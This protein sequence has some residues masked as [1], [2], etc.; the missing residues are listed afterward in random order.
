MRLG[1]KA[2]V[3]DLAS[4]GE[5]R[6]VV[7]TGPA[8]EQKKVPYG[9]FLVDI[10]SPGSPKFLA[11]LKPVKEDGTRG[12]AEAIAILHSD[13]D[14]LRVV[15]MFDSLPSGGPREYRVPLR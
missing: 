15:V 9:L 12:K 2:G 11:T 6:F 14:A 8:Q 10:A 5:G 13:A 7:L 4:L 3:R 1:K